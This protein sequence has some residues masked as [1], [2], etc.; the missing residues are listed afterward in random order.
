MLLATQLSR[1]ALLQGNAAELLD[2]AGF[3]TPPACLLWHDR[4]LAAVQ[5]G[6]VGDLA[7]S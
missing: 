5:C 1:P 4:M 2:Y 3:F 7:S 6:H